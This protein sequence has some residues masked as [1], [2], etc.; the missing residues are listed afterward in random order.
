M[1][2]EEQGQKLTEK[3]RSKK[4]LLKKLQK[5]R[6]SGENPMGKTA[7]TTVKMEQKE[8]KTELPAVSTIKGEMHK[9]GESSLKSQEVGMKTEES[10]RKTSQTEGCVNK[11]DA[12]WYQKNISDAFDQL[13]SGLLQDEQLHMLVEKFTLEIRRCMQY[14]K[15]QP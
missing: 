15:L 1:E 4:V 7:T 9:T 5:L 3:E 11:E 13:K 8:T 6:K 14:I 10:K 2:F 12:E